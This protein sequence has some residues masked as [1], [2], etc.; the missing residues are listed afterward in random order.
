MNTIV[1]SM[2]VFLSGA[3]ILNLNAEVYFGIVT[4][5]EYISLEKTLICSIPVFDASEDIRD[6][7][8]PKNEAVSFIHDKTIALFSQSQT[9][10]PAQSKYIEET[11]S[12]EQK[13]LAIE[14][15]WNEEYFQM[16]S[17]TEVKKQFVE[18][19]KRKYRMYIGYYSFDE[20]NFT[21]TAQLY[22]VDGPNV[23]LYMLS[24]SDKEDVDVLEEQLMLFHKKC[25]YS[26]SN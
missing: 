16:T 3:S 5:K 22:T 2:L 15:Y 20:E 23:I 11:M 4:S 8:Y 1:K 13:L 18:L 9:V 17:S 26:F 12:L 21:S 14:R 7:Y 24:I 25:Q 6:S 19:N 10:A